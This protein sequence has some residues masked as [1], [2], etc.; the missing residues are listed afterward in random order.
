ME[1]GRVK[2]RFSQWGLIP[3]WQRKATLPQGKDF[4]EAEEIFYSYSMMS[5]LHRKRCLIPA[6]AFFVQDLN[7]MTSQKYQV[8]LFGQQMFCF[9][10]VYDLWKTAKGKTVH[11]IS[12]LTVASNR[13]LT[14]HG[15]R[16]PL[17]LP[18]EA[19]KQWLQDRT[20]MNKLTKLL[21]PYHPNL[22]Q[23]SPITPTIKQ[24]PRIVAA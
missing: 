2:L 11:T 3:A 24:T 19:E 23:I 7:P 14:K 8:S 9:A 10:G 17:I 6:D 4:I 18:R 16:M 15:S 5:I 21:K 22:M 12:I 13:L 1:Y 20:S